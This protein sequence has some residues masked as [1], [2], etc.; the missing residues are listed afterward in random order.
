MMFVGTNLTNIRILHGYTRK[1]LAQMLNVTEQAVWQYENGYMSPKMEIVNELKRVFNVRSKYFYTEDLLAQSNKHSINHNFIAYRATALNSI[2]KT[3]TEAK[4]IEYINAFLRL[5]EEKLHFPHNGIVT[6]REKIIELMNDDS[7]SRDENIKR[8]AQHAR[9]YLELNKV[10]NGNLLF[11]LEKKGAFI[12]EKAIGEKIDAYS[13]WSEN[14][15]PYIILG[16]LKKSAVRRNFDLAHELGHLLMHYKVEFS[17][18]DKK[19]HKEYENEAN[20]FAG[21][22]LL[23]EE[24]LKN[25]FIN[26]PK[27]SNPDSY[28]DLKRKW[29]VSIQAIAYR[30]YSLELIN[31]QQYRYFHMMINQKGYKTI[32]PLDTEIKIMKPGKVKSILQLLFDKGYLSLGTLLNT[33]KVDLDFLVQLLGIEKEFF[34]KYK[35]DTTKQFTVTDLNIKAK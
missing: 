20:K 8:A 15:K 32:E 28:I 16:N 29:L 7:F 18:L 3:L 24:D 13:V 12:L 17:S 21:I 14:N 19:S 9:D 11:M 5:C 25:D 34:E 4:H 1:Q 33:L 27:S 23:P 2:P 22:F 31:Y 26:L 35:E 10:G 30:A 6:L